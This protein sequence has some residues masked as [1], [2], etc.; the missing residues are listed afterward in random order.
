MAQLWR[1][2]NCSP[3]NDPEDIN[4]GFKAPLAELAVFGGAHALRPG[5]SIAKG[6]A[7]FMRAKAEDPA[8]T[9]GV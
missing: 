4:S 8:P 6:E 9:A 5:Q 2:W 3:L 1:T 7:L